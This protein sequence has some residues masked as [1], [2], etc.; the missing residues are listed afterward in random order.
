MNTA[1]LELEGL[2]VAIAAVNHLLVQKGLITQTELQ[3]VLDHAHDVAK[4]A[5]SE[6]ELSGSNR[7]AICFPIRFLMLA[8][9]KADRGEP[10]DFQSV[11]RDIGRL[12]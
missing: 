2:Y 5:A 3:G 1:N 12:F 4:T 7:E 9:D 11:T 10:I 8:C 6:R